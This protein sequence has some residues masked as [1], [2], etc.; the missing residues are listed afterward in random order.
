VYSGNEIGVFGG[1]VPI[2]HGAGWITA[3]GHLSRLDVA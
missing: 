3:Y 2:D 1:L